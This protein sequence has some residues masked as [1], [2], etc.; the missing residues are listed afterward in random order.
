MATTPPALVRPSVYYR[1]S[2]L[3]ALREFQAEGRYTNLDLAALAI[4]F[5]PFVRSLLDDEDRANIPPHFVPSSH[6]WLVQ[7]TDFLGRI[8]LR[9]ELNEQL[10]LLGG[11]IGYEIRPSRR[12]HGHG[13]RILGLAL[14]RARERGLDRVLITCDGDNIASRRI[15]ERHGGI[16]DLPYA[17]P[18]GRVAV[19]RY[20]IDLSPATA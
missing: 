13:T 10:R 7:G 11:H 5:A 15:I 9:H 1:D 2:T 16:P 6:Y 18:G 20:W 3:S 4:D 12:R 14:P 19:L 8:S 17:P